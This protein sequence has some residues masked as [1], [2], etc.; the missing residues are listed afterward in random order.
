MPI[1]YVGHDLH[2]N[3]ELNY[4]VIGIIKGEN[5]QEDQ[6][7]CAYLNRKK[8][9]GIDTYAGLKMFAEDYEKWRT[10]LKVVWR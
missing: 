5:Y 10:K 1:G 6:N 9:Q 8:T 4:T 3:E 2:H 7:I